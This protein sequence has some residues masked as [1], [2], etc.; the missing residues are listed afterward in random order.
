MSIL[1]APVWGRLTASPI[2]LGYGGLI[3]R[4]T[5][6]TWPERLALS[7][8]HAGMLSSA[9]LWPDGIAL[10]G[11]YLGLSQSGLPGT[12]AD[13]SQ[14]ELYLRAMRPHH[15]IRSLT[16]R[17]YGINIDVRIVV[18]P[19]GSSNIVTTLL[20]PGT[21]LGWAEVHITIPDLPCIVTM[22]ARRQAVASSIIYAAAARERVLKGSDL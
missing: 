6:A 17:I 2:D 20:A 10:F 21:I 18:S 9:M 22:S 11:T 1:V 8:V 12:R 4:A 13:Y 3:T 16:I 7:Y 5:I 14:D 15:G 19:L